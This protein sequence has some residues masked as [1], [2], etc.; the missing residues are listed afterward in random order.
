[1]P[2][3][4]RRLFGLTLRLANPFGKNRGRQAA[5]VF[6]GVDNFLFAARVCFGK[7]KF[8]MQSAI[9]RRGE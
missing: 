7:D 4:S 9:Y 3:I 2:G 8:A 5:G 1:L 6:A